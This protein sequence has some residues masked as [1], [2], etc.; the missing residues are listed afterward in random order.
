MTD[1]RALPPPDDAPAN[2]TPWAQILVFIGGVA[3]MLF[4]LLPS[5]G[6]DEGRIFFRQPTDN[7][8]LPMTTTLVF[9]AE[10]VEGGQFNVLVNAPFIAPEQPMPTDDERY[11]ALPGG[12][13][14]IEVELPEGE[15]VLRA[16]YS[17][18]DGLALP[19]RD[20]II[21]TVSADAPEQAVYFVEPQEGDIVPERFDVVMGATGLI[22]EPAG[23]TE[24]NAG[25]L[26]ILLD[27]DFVPAGEVIPADEQHRHFGDG[28]TEVELTLPP[29]EHTLRLQFADGAHVALEGEQ[30]RDEI[31]I[32]VED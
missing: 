9:G 19:Y 10:G 26:H 22:I 30:Y 29:G 11:I 6:A 28:A 27:T 16:Q 32:T 4:L 23:E 1:E 25:H 20:Q 3:L 14:S 8:L 17:D 21:V 13:S 12:E 24:E 31:T 5:G 18:A 7:A 15:H 2:D